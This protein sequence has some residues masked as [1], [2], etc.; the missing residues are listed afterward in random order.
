MVDR[1]GEQFGNYRLVKLLGR[2]GFADVY[3][4]E[5]IHLGSHVA[6]KILHALLEEHEQEEFLLEARLIASLEHPSIVPVVDCAIEKNNAF[7]VMKYAPHGTLR[8]RYPKGT[9]LPL[10]E[11]VEIVRQVGAALQF[12]HNR[13][14]IHRDVKPENMLLGPHDEVLLSDFG[15][16]I[17]SSSTGSQKTQATAGTVAYMAPEQI[18]GKPRIA[19][20]QYALGIVVY[21]WLCGERPFHGSFPELCA[22][23]LYAPPPSLQAKNSGI[24]PAVEAIVMRALAKKPEQRF[25]HVSDFVAALQDACQ[26]TD[27]IS[28]FVMSSPPQNTGKQ[29]TL[30]YPGISRPDMVVPGY[31][32]DESTLMKT[33]QEISAPHITPATITPWLGAIEQ[34]SQGFAL[35]NTP[36]PPTFY[37]QEESV[38]LTKQVT[39]TPEPTHVARSWK[40]PEGRNKKRPWF[41]IAATVLIA[42]ALIG[43][44]FV[45]ALR[46]APTSSI[47]K[48]TTAQ[49]PTGAST[50][51]SGTFSSPTSGHTA[52]KTT[53]QTPGTTLGTT[54]TTRPTQSVPTQGPHPT[55]KPDPGPPTV[56][57]TTPPATLSVSPSSLENN[58]SNCQTDSHGG[59]SYLSSC[60]LVIST[61]AQTTSALN[62]SVTSDA[63]GTTFDQ[64][65]GSIAPG[66]PVTI[67][68]FPPNNDQVCPMSFTLTFTGPSNTVQVPIN[69]TYIMTSPDSNTF[70]NTQ[71]TNNTGSWVCVIT[72]SASPQNTINT[73]W[74]VTLQTPDPNIIIPVT[75]GTLGPGAATQVTITIPDSDCP[76]NNVIEFYVPGGLPYGTNFL[77]WSC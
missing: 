44:S 71:C 29:Q 6:I 63:P 43:G 62:W 22:Q 75:Q 54:P 20:D 18:M 60:P 2:G 68:V 27:Q 34:D 73:Q 11:I 35:K 70:D 49:D 21:E 32:G 23:H 10:P 40:D 24:S 67:N 37:P 42:L 58:F 33:P 53:G 55:P 39:F 5:H 25:Q 17:L 65:T 69:C 15:I 28:T 52:T 57:V 36:L 64:S 76:T 1:I 8:Q 72:V 51:T 19:S 9:R 7:I 13:R 16:A 38:P 45:F 66:Q 31:R 47:N 41:L 26:S 56:T 61:S 4:G 14:I 12:A 77:S 30:S 3:L 74:A 50:P 59:V 48:G 46:Q